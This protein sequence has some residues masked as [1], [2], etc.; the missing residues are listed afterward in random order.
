MTISDIH[1]EFFSS[2]IIYS[3]PSDC[4]AGVGEE[5]AEGGIWKT[6]WW[7]RGMQTSE[8]KKERRL[9]KRE[10]ERTKGKRGSAG[11]KGDKGRGGAFCQFKYCLILKYI[12][13]HW[14]NFSHVAASR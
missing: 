3:A 9:G 1:L 2:L 4:P 10:A 5:K 11:K 13:L 8:T 6:K 12:S 7:E 14:L